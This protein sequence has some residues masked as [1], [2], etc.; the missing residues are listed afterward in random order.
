MPSVLF[1]CVLS[2]FRASSGVLKNIIDAANVQCQL[3]RVMMVAHQEI[4]T[5]V[6]VEGCRQG[7]MDALRLLYSGLYP[8]L[9][10]TARRYVDNDT[11]RD[12]VHDSFLMALTS[13]NSLRDDRRIEAWLTRIVR[14]MA[15]N[16]IK[17]DRDIQTLPL[18]AVQ[19]AI[20]DET[21]DEPLIPLDVLMSMVRSL[22]NGYEQVF[23]L[24][25]LAGL[26]HDEIS[27][28][29]GISSSTSRSQYTHA[30][31]ML[32]AMVQH[33]WMAPISLM[34]AILIYVGLNQ[35]HKHPEITMPSH[36]NVADNQPKTATTTTNEPSVGT[37]ERH[38][39]STQPRLVA[40]EPVPQDS[41]VTALPA[42]NIADSEERNQV[43]DSTDNS[44]KPLQETLYIETPNLAMENIKTQ[45]PID[46]RNHRQDNSH[47]SIAMAF[48]GLSDQLN[49]S[50][51]AS[52]TAVS[53]LDVLTPPGIPSS[54]P[55][56]QFVDFDNWTDYLNF[57]N[58]EAEIDP[59]EK[60]LSL[61]RIAQSNV[62]GNPQQNIEERVHHDV[63]FTVG[64]SMNK[65]ITNQWSLGTGL[66]Y[67]FMHS[68][69]DIGYPL[70]FIRN[71]Q[72]IHYLGIPVN[73]SF[74]FFDN[75]RWTL[76]GNAG[77]T[78]DVPVANAWHTY[79]ILFNQTIYSSDNKF[80]LPLQWSVNAGLGVQYNFTP[81][82][83]IFAQPGVNY[84]FDNGTKTI[85]SAHPWNVTIPIGL[86]F[87]W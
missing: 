40:N 84:Y 83:G 33:W 59:S 60:N 38:Q 39:V 61:Q 31:R 44:G 48:S 19:D 2:F 79:H 71:E 22:P 72:T 74:K 25:T 54:I 23:R 53:S 14:N 57:I 10:E 47:M 52:I 20:P 73:A 82:I 42:I 11:A 70:A 41:T 27:R 35:L 1:C 15:L 86:R 8:S 75:G 64:L 5:T 76:Y 62:L 32:K 24:R 81:R 7:N 67:T 46:W 80:S 68:T 9:L 43:A 78:L 77:A 87:T 6:L 49:Q 45:N 55:D 3:S 51:A 37:G 17:H 18:E 21:P 4:E 85:R 36:P 29:L 34:L 56:K 13:L 12:V 58:K 16:H 65:T 63:P 30:R 66:N 50:N 26:S 69:F 28:R